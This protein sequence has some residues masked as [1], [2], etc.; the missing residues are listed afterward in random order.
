VAKSKKVNPDK[1]KAILRTARR[2]DVQRDLFADPHEPW[3]E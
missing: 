1:Q 2:E 3:Q